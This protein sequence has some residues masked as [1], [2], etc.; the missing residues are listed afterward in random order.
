MRMEDRDSPIVNFAQLATDSKRKRRVEEKKDHFRLAS[1]A[2]KEREKKR[3]KKA[4]RPRRV[5]RPTEKLEEELKQ[6]IICGTPG[7]E[8]RTAPL[9]SP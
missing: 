8:P 7:T 3:K 9:T 2:G 1:Y 4:Q 6:K 5:F